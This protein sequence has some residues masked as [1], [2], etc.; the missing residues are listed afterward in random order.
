MTDVGIIP[1]FFLS[2]RFLGFPLFVMCAFESL[3]KHNYILKGVSLP[4][5][6]ISMGFLEAAGGRRC[7]VVFSHRKETL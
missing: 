4:S 3:F 7:S 1:P 2:A 6:W 5:L